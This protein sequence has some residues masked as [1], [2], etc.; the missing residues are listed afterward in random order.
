MAR[1]P[2]HGWVASFSLSLVPISWDPVNTQYV[3][4]E[5]MRALVLFFFKFGGCITVY[6]FSLNQ[7]FKNCIAVFKII[8]KKHFKFKAK[9]TEVAE[10]RRVREMLA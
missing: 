8:I 10:W 6:N 3:Y 7:I 9:A 4:V 2:G 1:Q 5:G